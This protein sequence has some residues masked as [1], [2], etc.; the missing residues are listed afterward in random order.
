MDALRSWMSDTVFSKTF[1]AANSRDNTDI[2]ENE[3][4]YHCGEPFDEQ[5]NKPY[6]HAGPNGA[7]HACH[8][9]CVK[10][11]LDH[12]VKS[13]AENFLCHICRVE[14]HRKSFLQKTIIQIDSRDWIERGIG[15]G[16]GMGIGE[17]VF[18]IDKQ[19]PKNFEMIASI[20]G[21]LTCF[22][23]AF[24]GNRNLTAGMSIGISIA[25]C[26]TAYRRQRNRIDQI[27]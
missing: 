1:T 25:V 4:Y 7:R 22:G 6:I 21:M 18:N 17:L 24:S 26:E 5:S 20:I 9:R 27:A 10:P 16:L 15:F 3:C 14:I 2:F 19:H 13:A 8:Q 12:Y 23:I 11:Y